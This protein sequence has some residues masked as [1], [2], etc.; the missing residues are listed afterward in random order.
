MHINTSVRATSIG[1]QIGEPA[2][3]ATVPR[4]GR[5]GELQQLQ[6]WCWVD[7]WRRMYI[8]EQQKMPRGRSGGGPNVTQHKHILVR[9]KFQVLR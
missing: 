2:A 6:Q 3:E 7:D 8:R 5:C 1:R 4:L 9:P